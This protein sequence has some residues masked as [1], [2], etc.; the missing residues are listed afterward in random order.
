MPEPAESR[1][2]QTSSAPRPSGGCLKRLFRASLWVLL[3]VAIFH[4]P[5]FHNLARFALK[6]VAARHDLNLE[7]RFSGNI[8]TTLV[9]EKI[10]AV[11]SG[12]EETPVDRI[13]IAHLRLNYSIP[14]L[15]R[16]GLGEFL[17]SY[18]I[19]DAELSFVARERKREK[20]K[21]RARSLAETLNDLLAQPAAYADQVQ[22]ENFNLRIRSSKDLTELRGLHLFLHPE[23]PGYLRIARL[24]VP[25]LEGWENLQAETSY[26]G[27][28]FSIKGLA[29]TPE[30]IIDAAN[31][32]ASQRA[33]NKG[34]V[35]VSG[36]FFGGTAEGKLTGTRL[37]QRGENLEKSYDTTLNVKVEGVAI[38]R[39]VAYFAR[40]KIPIGRLGRLSLDIRGQPEKP[41]T[42]KGRLTA[43][44]EQIA[45]GP[46]MIDAIELATDFARGKAQIVAA[47]TFAGGNKVSLVGTVGL[48][49]S[50]NHFEQSEVD[51]QMV[52]DAPDL[53]RLTAPLREPINGKIAGRGKVGLHAQI[54]TVDLSLDVDK[55]GNREIGMSS[56]NI[57][58][59][60]SKPVLF[61]KDDPLRGLA[62]HAT[63]ELSSLRFAAA[64]ADSA[65]FDLRADGRLL[66]AN[67]IE[68]IR[69]GNH[70]K[71]SGTY[72]ILTKPAPLSAQF[73]INAPALREFGLK[74]KEATV[75]GKLEGEGSV[76]YSGD[77]FGG[78]VRLAGSGFEVGKFKAERLAVRA[79][80][81]NNEAIIDQL[82]FQINAR[83]RISAT[84]KVG[85][86]KPFPYKG[87]LLVQIADLGIFKP[88][89][90]ILGRSEK[91]AGSLEIDWNGKGGPAPAAPPVAPALHHSG[92]LSVQLRE[93]AY[94]KI[95]IDQLRLAGRY[96]AGFAESSEFRLVTGPTEL[97]G[98]IE[99]REGRLR[100]R[101]L[102]LQQGAITVLTGYIL[103][104]FNPEDRSAPIPLDKRVA[105]NLN[106]RE[107]DLEKLLRSFGKDAP[108]TGQITANLVMG[109]TL[110]EPS[111]H[112]KVE[113]RKLKAKA[114]AQIEGADL[115]LVSHFSENE[116]TLD[117]T[118]RQPQVAPL[119]IK[120]RAPLNLDDTVKNKRI[121]PE[122]PVE[123]TVNLPQTSLAFVPKIVPQVRR[124]EGNAAIEARL[125]GTVGKPVL[126]GSATVNV[127]S[128]RLANENVPSIGG[129]RAALSFQD[130]TL[131]V[132]TLRGEVG[133]GTFAV[134]GAIRLPKLTEPVFDL[135]FESDEVLVKRDDSVT[136]RVDTELKL[137]GPLNRA[138]ASG[139]VFVTN[140]RFFR[141]IDIL[142]I[143]LPGRPKPK[144]QPR[145]VASSNTLSFDKPP[146]RDWIFE[147]AIK[148]RP[149]D[150]FRI[151]G[152]LARGGA[153]LDLKFGGTG[154]EPW[155][156]GTVRVEDFVASL[157][158]SKLSVTRGFIYFKE[159]APFEPQLDLQAESTL[160]DYHVT[161]YI[162][163]S[164]KDP[165]LSLTSEPPLPQQEII[166]LL[167]TGATTS[168]LGQGDALAGRAAVLVFQQLYRKVFKRREPAEEEGLM[169]RFEVDVGSVDNRT[170]RQE[171]SATFKLGENYYLVGDLDVA[172]DFTGRLKYLLRFR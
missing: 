172:G 161:A 29:V 139:E 89:L 50:V 98:G 69:G 153:A 116:L 132:N 117:A 37:N 148:T 4:R 138:T 30:I 8:F 158:F 101:D 60:L 124:I 167:A 3:V 142:P 169:E 17:R 10:R 87:A 6:Q 106:A 63:G 122:L 71:L 54:A 43:R 164:A 128:A 165:Q 25:N 55:V 33:Y 24:K 74:I 112:L 15:I 58:A 36:R 23:Q 107:L 99:V 48:P 91:I 137:E 66:T 51:A 163:G 78:N 20:E 121:N 27:R 130:D 38:D 109:G 88:L 166:S 110:L 75:D 145:A 120:G 134:S 123:L 67:T 12:E 31:F 105:A 72:G 96:G 53:A 19:R 73:T 57:R 100:L 59:N 7:I 150:P 2:P 84:G 146:L 95:A 144:P 103:L 77:A 118:V 125:R 159:D 83:D 154:L 68:I 45:A 42:W 104:P 143:Q 18:E 152:N 151:R 97:Q 79:D 35:F 44:A 85:A 49:A 5:L 127:Q 46:V 156:D 93:A 149:G 94:D 141:E 114:A 39:A 115:D 126:G 70:L 65:R 136:V 1:K 157:P 13:E 108:A 28:N 9:V 131:Q 82:D 170:G 56:G 119:T 111:A 113:G 135:R 81:V 22:I 171:I 92:E 90:E 21:R 162:Y 14:Q 41:V 140:S 76:R 61:S 160:R 40:R 133:G 102:K 26:V 147:I 47:D 80:V 168:E 129:L 64:Q 34:S 155:L 32:D 62:G 86:L 52:V 16:H 11:P